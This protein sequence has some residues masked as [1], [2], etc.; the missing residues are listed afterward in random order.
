MNIAQCHDGIL[1]PP[2]IIFTDIISDLQITYI[3]A[4]IIQN[5][6]ISSTDIM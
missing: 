5:Y 3:L 6:V 2:S 4:Y 1:K